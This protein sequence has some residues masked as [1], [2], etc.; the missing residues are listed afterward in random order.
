MEDITLADMGRNQSKK[1]ATDASENTTAAAASDN[2][3]EGTSGTLEDVTAAAPGASENLAAVGAPENQATTGTPENLDDT[4]N[5]KSHFAIPNLVNLTNPKSNDVDSRAFMGLHLKAQM[6]LVNA[7]KVMLESGHHTDSADMGEQN[8]QDHS[9][10]KSVTDTI[11]AMAF[12]PSSEHYWPDSV[13]ASEYLT[14]AHSIFDGLGEDHYQI[15]NAISDRMTINPNLMGSVHHPLYP[16]NVPEDHAQLCHASI[17]MPP[18]IP[19]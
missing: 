2:T 4:N 15:G 18:A 14:M 12:G 10:R 1:Q 5:G 7:Y 6:R 13:R 19:L 16:Y 17:S 11:S 9:H 8:H 3:A